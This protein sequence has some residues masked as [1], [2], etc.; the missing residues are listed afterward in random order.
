VERNRKRGRKPSA[1]RGIPQ[2]P[3]YLSELE[4]AEW[5]RVAKLLK[6]AG[7]LEALD[8]TALAA[9]CNCYATWVDANS[10]IKDEGMVIVSTMGFPIQSP[11]VGIANKALANMMAI[12]REFGMTP[13]SRSK[14]PTKSAEEQRPRRVT[15]PHTVDPR[16]FLELTN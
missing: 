9:Y 8:K 7:L 10:H 4:R 2:A 16:E 5:R 12:L 15:R 11:Y 6:A 3:E 13:A 1:A 14:L